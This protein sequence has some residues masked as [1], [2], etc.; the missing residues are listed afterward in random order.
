MK[1]KN[2]KQSVIQLLSG[3]L[4]RISGD[5]VGAYAAQAAYFLMLS[6]IPFV[7]FLTTFIRY[8]PLTYNIMRDAIISI[9]PQNLQSFVLSVVADIY[10]IS[11]AVVP[12]TAV[13][14]L[15]SAG[16]GVQSI[17]NGLNTI[18]HVKETRNWLITRIYSVIYTML[19]VISLIV[20]LLLLV[21]GNRIQAALAKYLPFLGRIIGGIIGAR[22]FLVFGVLFAVFLLIYKVLPNRK[23]TLKSQVPGA[24][25]IAVAWSAFSY[26]FSIYFEMFP[27]FSNMYGNLAT[28]IMVM[29]WLYACMN[30]LLYGAEINAYFEKQFRMAQESMREIISREK[31]QKAAEEKRE[32]TSEPEGKK[33]RKSKLS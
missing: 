9:V 4:D 8:T 6:F 18:Y 5:H 2:K 23:A 24:F 11:T 14:A 1:R 20:S 19:F 29:L 15:W 28:V 26:G 3:F 25:L 31:E 17:T 33:Q 30:L 21:L 7:L 13:I 32:E 12:I 10:D 22:A 16:K 27:N